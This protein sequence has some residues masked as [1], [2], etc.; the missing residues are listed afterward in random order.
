MTMNLITILLYTFL[1]AKPSPVFQP[2][3]KTIIADGI[4]SNRYSILLYDKER[5]GYKFNGDVTSTPIF[6]SDIRK[7][8]TLT[9]ESVSD[10]NEMTKLKAK[11]KALSQ[12]QLQGN[13][14]A[15]DFEHIPDLINTA[16]YYKQLIAVRN[17]KGEKEVWVSCFY[18]KKDKKFWRERLVE[19]S[20]NKGRIFALKINLATDEIS[21]FSFLK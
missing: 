14:S 7:I 9:R 13:N 2:L 15:S 17:L 18:N 11:Q 20:T 1:C 5:D 4:D 19:E 8:E 3:A 10:F 12:R 21:N 16:I 6:A